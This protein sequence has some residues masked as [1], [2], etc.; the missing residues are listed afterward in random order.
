MAA[1]RALH[2]WRE[3]IAAER[4]VAPFRVMNNEV[5]V[6]VARR[7]PERA[8]QLHGIRGLSDAVIERRGDA[9]LGAVREAQ[10]LAESELPARKRG[11]GR[12]P[13]DPELDALIDRLKSAR[14]AAADRLQIDRGFLMP[15]QQLEDIARRRPA[16]PEA[17]LEVPDMRRW[18]VE[19]MSEELL[20][21][22]TPAA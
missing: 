9:L 1:L 13:P 2:G 12:P 7:L 18:Q 21:V 3:R 19:A 11:P 10:Q 14:D 15:R 4:D 17:L 8:D 20:A 6:E 22:I 5:L 16:T